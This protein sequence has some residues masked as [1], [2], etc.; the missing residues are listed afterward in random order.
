MYYITSVRNQ[1][2]PRRNL[3]AVGGVEEEIKIVEGKTL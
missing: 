3:S 2:S 1:R